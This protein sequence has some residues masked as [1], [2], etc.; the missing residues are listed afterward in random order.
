MVGEPI[1]NGIRMRLEAEEGVLRAIGMGAMQA[2][3]QA[4][5]Q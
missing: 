2:Q 4:A 5:G 1:E 3:M